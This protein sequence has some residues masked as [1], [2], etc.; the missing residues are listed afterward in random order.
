MPDSL[1]RFKSDIFQAL[2][3]PTRI[4]ILEV[5]TDGELSAGEIIEKLGM[6]QANVSQHLAVMRARQIVTNRKAGNQVFYSIRDP[7]LLKVLALMR[8]YFQNHLKETQAMLDQIDRTP[9]ERAR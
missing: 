3:N 8:Q 2:A 9:A 6:E 4:A 7:I 1:R 5:L